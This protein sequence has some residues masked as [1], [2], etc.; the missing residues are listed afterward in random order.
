MN[1]TGMLI[2]ATVVGPVLGTLAAPGFIAAVLRLARARAQKVQHVVAGGADLYRC[3]VPMT[4]SQFREMFAT[5]RAELA[6]LPP[7][8]ERTD[9]EM[10]QQFEAAQRLAVLTGRHPNA[11]PN[12]D[13]PDQAW[14]WYSANSPYATGQTPADPLK[15]GKLL[16]DIVPFAPWRRLGTAQ[17]GF[18]REEL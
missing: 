14:Q 13:D 18:D 5:Y 1:T 11:F 16:R 3:G 4:E 2:L 6:K 7:P 10:K 12:V 9:W 15:S 17:G 8:A